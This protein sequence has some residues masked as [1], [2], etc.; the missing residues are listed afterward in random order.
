MPQMLARISSAAL[1]AVK[2]EPGAETN[3]ATSAPARE[4]A[5][6]SVGPALA[7]GT[8]GE[9]EAPKEEA[10][11]EDAPAQEAVATEQHKGTDDADAGDPGKD[12]PPHGEPPPKRRR[13]ALLS[14]TTHATL[15]SRPSVTTF[16]KRNHT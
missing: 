13:V 2:L 3:A 15:S 1:S 12:G 6:S 8:T 5:T 4:N 11:K 10:P 9:P 16:C 14:L 7:V